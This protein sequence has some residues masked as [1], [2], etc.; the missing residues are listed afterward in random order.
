[1]IKDQE[2]MQ[3][4]PNYATITGTKSLYIYVWVHELS[5]YHSKKK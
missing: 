3:M 1:M 5:I 2:C 4:S